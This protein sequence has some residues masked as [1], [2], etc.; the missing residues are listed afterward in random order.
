MLGRASSILERE[1]KK[2]SSSLL[3]SSNAGNLANTFDV[4][5]RASMIGTSEAARLT[6]LVQDAQKAKDQDEDQAP[7]APAAAVYESQS[8]GI[9]ETLQDLREKAESQLAD[10][11]KKEVTARHNFE[12]L[13]QSLESE[14]KNAAE[15]MEGAKKAIA[16]S[17]EKKSTAAGE[18][19]V[20]SKELAADIKTKGSLHQDCLS[21]ASA[22][23]AETKSRGEE[24]KA[25]AK[26][27]QII[28]EATG[29]GSFGQLSLL[30]VGRSKLASGK[31]LHR[32]EAVRIIRDLARKQH[33]SALVQL[34]SQMAGAMNSGDAFKK[35]K[36]LISD[37]IAKLEKAAGADA[38][39]K[40]YCDKELAESNAK[41]SDKSDEISKLTTKIEQMAAKSSQLKEQVAALESELSNLAK[42]QAQMDKLRKEEQAVYEESKAELDKG[43]TGIK[44]ALKILSEYYGQDGKAHEA[45]EG[46]AG[47]IISLL[48]VVEADFSKNLA[49]ITADEEAAAAEYEQAS[50]A[51]EIEKTAK[52]QDVKYK[53]KES[54][55]LDKSSAELS[56]DRTGVQ[57]ELDAVS[58]YL[59]KIEGECIA[60]AETYESR[61]ARRESEIAGLKKALQILESE[62]ALVQSQTMRRTLR[63]SSRALEIG[64]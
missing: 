58:E 46:A 6:S 9:V 2:G 56:S 16:E 45:S 31:D 13:K 15:D 53:I 37:M 32:Y 7:G 12:M 30:Q 27:K 34:A 24:L 52:D 62:V 39:K 54:K 22:V 64:A 19:G 61:K 50:K 57:A 38:T 51:N 8:G 33:S 26:A 35:V 4:M 41:K 20:T 21:K 36:G 47:G 48:E 43:L 23:Q 63:G 25:L 44:Q 28:A 42:S 49:Q 40:A 60:K 59:S 10:T 11:R 14:G 29:G 55:G 17:S 1:M 18:L 3:Q 5:V